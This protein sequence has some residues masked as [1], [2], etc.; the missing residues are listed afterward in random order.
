MNLNLAY[1]LGGIDYMDINN[2]TAVGYQQKIIRTTDG[3]NSWNPQISPVAN[4][5]FESVLMNSALNGVIV[6][7]GG[8]ILYTTSGGDPIGISPISNLVPDEYALEQNY[9]NP[10][11][12]TTNF[13]FKI[14]DLGFVNLTIYD[15]TGREVETLVNE[16]LKPGTYK[17]DWDATN[18]V[19]GVYFCK[20]IAGDFTETK[21]MV[22][23]K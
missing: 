1:W 4:T 21:H 5:T 22:L 11:N 16:E 19:S 13:E 2:T 18:F 7:G 23:V 17:A 3:G 15:A 8:V 12:P 9:P 20:L 10:F 6:G 14:A